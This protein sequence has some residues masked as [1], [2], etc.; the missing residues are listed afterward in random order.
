MAMTKG[1]STKAQ[2]LHTTSRISSGYR[3][4]VLTDQKGSKQYPATIQL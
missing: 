4:T 3:D 1:E 2:E